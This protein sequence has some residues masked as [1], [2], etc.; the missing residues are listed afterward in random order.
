MAELT[1]SIIIPTINEADTLPVLIDQLQQQKNVCLE[2]IVVDG[3]SQ[4]NTIG[5]AQQKHARVVESKKGRAKQMNAGA[6][7][8]QYSTLFFLHA[9]SEIDDVLFLF[10]ALDA[11]SQQL[12]QQ[13]TVA[14]H[15]SLSFKRQTHKHKLAFRY[16]EAKSKTNR[17]QT[18]NGDQ[19]LIIQRDFFHQ[20]G[21]YDESLPVMEDQAI[22]AHIFREGQ[23]LLL[24][25]TLTTSGRRFETEG[26]HRRYIL[27]GLMM[28]L[29]WTDTNQFFVRVKNVY[30][31]Q[32]RTAK[33]KLWPF[34][35]CIW[36]MQIED[37]GLKQSFIQWYRVGRYVRQNSWQLFFYVDVYLGKTESHPWLNIHDKYIV[38]LINNV[39]CDLVI[40]PL[41]FIWYMLILGPWFFLFD[42]S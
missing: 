28:G 21:G 5:I 27:M 25:G 3:G 7:V 23:W 42:E 26:F 20:L 10:R 40:T 6:K 24:P 39:V 15:F 29:F 4:D 16:L 31:E 11:F 12:K 9:D 30:A 38:R 36:R 13:S 33:L 41:V 35:Y 8:A 18:I 14:G 34:F 19:G 22:A 37:L 17:L 32:N 2:I 1:V